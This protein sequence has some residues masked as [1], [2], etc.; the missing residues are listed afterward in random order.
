MITLNCLV[1]L[2]NYK[3]NPSCIFVCSGCFYD[4]WFESS[5]SFR[6]I[7]H[8]SL[9]F[10][11]YIKSSFSGIF[12]LL[13]FWFSDCHEV[14]VYIQIRMC[15]RLCVYIHTL[16]RELNMCDT[17]VRC[18]FNVVGCIDICCVT[19]STTQRDWWPPVIETLHAYTCY[20]CFSCHR[21]LISFDFGGCAS[22]LVN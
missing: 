2:W 22:Y 10:F 8:V 16:Y 11:F 12:A 4:N 1:Q 13:H 19:R 7:L 5:W 9:S 18:P 17:D 6:G 3:W 21:F 14:Y 15:V 20:F